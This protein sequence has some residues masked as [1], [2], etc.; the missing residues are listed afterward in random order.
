VLAVGHGAGT[1]ELADRPNL[2]RIIAGL[3]TQSAGR[4]TID[5]VEVAA[6]PGLSGGARPLP[7]AL[8]AFLGSVGSGLFVLALRLMWPGLP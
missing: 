8:A 1:R 4:V 2:L 6:R 3:E 7:P 5:G